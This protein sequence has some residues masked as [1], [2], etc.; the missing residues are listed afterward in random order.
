[1]PIAEK[2]SSLPHRLMSSASVCISLLFGV[3]PLMGSHF[4]LELADEA[5]TVEA[6]R[7]F[8]NQLEQ[9]MV[10]YLHGDLGAGKTTFVRGVL[11]GLGYNGPVKSPTYTL[12][13]P[14]VISK[15]QLY[16]FDLYRFNDEE[17]WYAAGFNEYL[18]EESVSM[19]EWPERALSI[20]PKPDFD[21]S[22][23]MTESGGR[24]L[25]I[26]KQPTT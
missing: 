5:A 6:G 14:Y 10:I 17:E 26:N 16:H 11:R 18:N 15:F 7:A 13:E 25:V 24:K 3:L 8:S 22:L 23:T 19:I 9:G 20:L 21:I 1:M 2:P 12:V 4:T